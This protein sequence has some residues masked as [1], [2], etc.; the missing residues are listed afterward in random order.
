MSI[1]N[2]A[3]MT[4]PPITVYKKVVSQHPLSKAALFFRHDCNA[5]NK[6]LR[7]YP[8]NAVLQNRVRPI[9]KFIPIQMY[10]EAFCAHSVRCYVVIRVSIID[11]RQYLKEEALSI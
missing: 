11:G 5:L 7:F 9:D 10:S 3:L 1:S 2:Y 8:P 4:N 6:Q